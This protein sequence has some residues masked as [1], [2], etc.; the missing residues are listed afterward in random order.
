VKLSIDSIEGKPLILRIAG[1]G[2]ILGL[3]ATLSGSTYE[4]TAEA[5]RSYQV[6]FIRGDAFLRFVAA[7]P[8]AYRG[9]VTQII[10]LYNGPATNCGPSVS[11]LLFRK[12]LLVF[13]LIVPPT[14]RTPNKGSRSTSRS[15]MKRSLNALAPVGSR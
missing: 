1:V 3:T 11:P 15:P 10:G 6:A 8:E 5:L 9:A 2:E 4:V 7:H 13:C 12:S 14:C